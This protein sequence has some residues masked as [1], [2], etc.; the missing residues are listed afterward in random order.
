MD[1]KS[2]FFKGS[3][4]GVVLGVSHRWSD[5]SQLLRQRSRP[6]ALAIDGTLTVINGK[7]DFLSRI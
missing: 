5:W 1:P 7:Y 3:R 4:A 6:D 2:S